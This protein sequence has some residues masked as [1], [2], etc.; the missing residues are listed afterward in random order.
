MVNEVIALRQV[1]F[2]KQP[3]HAAMQQRAPTYLKSKREQAQ[4]LLA[5]SPGKSD[6]LWDG[7]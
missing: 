6:R 1:G 4:I 5:H 7:N 3:H 2:Q